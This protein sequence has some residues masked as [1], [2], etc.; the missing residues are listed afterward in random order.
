MMVKS[1]WPALRQTELKAGCRPL[2]HTSHFC[3]QTPT[4]RQVS[5]CHQQRHLMGTQGQRTQTQPCSL[6]AVRGPCSSIQTASSPCLTLHSADL[7][8]SPQCPPTVSRY[9]G[10]VSSAGGREQSM[11]GSQ[12]RGVSRKNPAVWATSVVSELYLNE[13]VPILKEGCGGR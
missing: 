7:L 5:F 2:L 9:Q 4:S 10:P 6:S 3:P 1:K 13:V 11:H 8:R 12:E